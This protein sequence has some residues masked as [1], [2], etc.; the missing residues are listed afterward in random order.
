MAPR[1]VLVLGGGVG[2]LVTANELRRR[3]GPS[4]R[5]VLVERERRHLAVRDERV[6]VRASAISQL[7][8][9]SSTLES[10]SAFV[11]RVATIE[12]AGVLP[13]GSRPWSVCESDLAVICDLVG[14]VGELVHYLGRRL[15]I[16]D[17]NIDANDEL[18]WFGR[19]L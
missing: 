10:L 9:V 12:E 4:D 5:V 17:L 1:T 16:E 19:Y 2:G 18:D 6:I 15:A 14:G 8:L 11:T 13:M 3:L 7:F